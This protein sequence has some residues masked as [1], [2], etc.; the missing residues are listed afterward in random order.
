[1]TT[2]MCYWQWQLVNWITHNKYTC[3]HLLKQLN[4]NLLYFSYQLIT[5]CMALGLDIGA[6]SIAELVKNI[7]A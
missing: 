3:A 6:K 5:I 4:I 7:I 2:T 1:M